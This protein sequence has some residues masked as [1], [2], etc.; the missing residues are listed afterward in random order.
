[1][2]ARVA[3]K[4]VDAADITII[5]DNSIDAL[6]ASTP[7]AQRQ[8]MT[9]DYFD[10]EQLRAEHGLSLLLTIT[11][12]GRRETILYDCGLSRDGVAHNLDVLGLSMDQVRTVVLSHGHA[13][14][15][16]GLEGLFA[17]VGRR[18]MPLVLHPDIWKERKV[19]FPTGAEMRIPPPSHNDLDR[20]GWEILEERGPSL[21]LED[22]VL[23]TGQVDRVT[24]FETGFPLQYELTD[25]GY[26]PDPWIWEDQAIVIH[27]R[28]KG[29]VILSGCGHAGV[30]NILRYAQALTGIDH[31][32][33]FVGG[34]HLTGGIFEPII[35]RTIDEVAAIGPDLLVPGH[36]TGWK[37][38]HLLAARL[39]DAYLPANV[40][41]RYHFTAPE[42]PGSRA[43][44]E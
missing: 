32:H 6:M 30:V 4:P 10:H 28:D 7:R 42:E 20:E 1:M 14:H 43:R 23:V 19:V 3:L 12:D 33:A 24:D 21:L 40:G 29:L 25:H 16:G 22:T 5:M 15:H 2:T 18:R 17:R 44:P 36:C 27:L 41:T 38:T 39:P 31:V 26:E 13:D 9:W 11:R 37:A 35:P 8:P 34:M